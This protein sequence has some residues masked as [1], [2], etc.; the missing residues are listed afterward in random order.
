MLWLFA[1][2]RDP[3]AMTLPVPNY[4]LYGET[5]ASPMPDILHCE[6]I[7][8]RS[9]VHDG[10]I[11]AHRHDGLTQVLYA[12]SGTIRATLE[13]A[14]FDLHGQFLILTP[15]LSIHGFDI[16]RDIDG[17]VLTLPDAGLRE[18]LAP[19]P[20]LLSALS[21]PQVI[22][23]GQSPLPFARVDDLFEHIASE[24]SGSHPARQFVL[25]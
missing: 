1:T 24:F 15:S 16:S 23:A 18:I 3:P 25:R 11:K 22:Q 10:A 5:N 13:D 12:R 9:R 2:H 14:T 21:Q 6:S 4:A 17:W 8:E 20:Q 19:A 7:A